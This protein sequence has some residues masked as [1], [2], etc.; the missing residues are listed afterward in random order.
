MS[1]RTAVAVVVVVVGLGC[2]RDLPTSIEPTSAA[3]T[4]PTAPTAPAITNEP[5]VTCVEAPFASSTPVPEASAAAWLTID[6]ALRLVVTSDSGNHGA[7]GIVDPDTG[8][9]TETGSWPLGDAGDDL[10][11]LAARDGKLYGL[12]SAGY[13]HVWARRAAGFALVDGPYPI[14]HGD[15]VCDAHDTNCAKNY[16]GLCL[17]AHPTGPCVGFAAAKAD[18]RLYCLVEAR[19]RLAVNPASSIAI[20]PA[21]ALADCAF[22]DADRLWV[23]SNI[24]ELNAV[25][26]V[27]GWQDPRTAKVTPIGA[28]GVGFS[29]VIAARGDLLYRMSDTGGAPSGM[30]KFRCT[31][32]ER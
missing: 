1:A 5:A 19:G 9:T 3:P 14:G 21:G 6:G 8:A 26:R 11:G 18:G 10:E 16:E 29:E 24:F 31:A 23:G 13:V 32:N 25:S 15:M 22:D 2:R 7:Y 20:S 4:A 17:A 30:A 28:I 12:S 27:D